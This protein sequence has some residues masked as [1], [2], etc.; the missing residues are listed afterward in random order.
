MVSSSCSPEIVSIQTPYSTDSSCLT[1][2]NNSFLIKVQSDPNTPDSLTK[3]SGISVKTELVDVQVTQGLAN[4]PKKPFIVW[5]HNFSAEHT[6]GY[7]AGINREVFFFF[8]FCS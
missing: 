4:V 2:S 1:S 8:F 6:E 3:P 7:C 5:I